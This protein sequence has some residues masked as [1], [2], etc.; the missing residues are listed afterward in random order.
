MSTIHRLSVILA[1]FLAY[2]WLVNGEPLPLSASAHTWFW[3]GLSGIV[4]FFLCDL[5][6]FKSMLI[7]GPRL[8]LLVFSLAPIIAALCGWIWLSEELSTRDPTPLGLPFSQKP[9]H[10]FHAPL[11][12]E[13]SW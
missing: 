8:T 6:L 2:G 13:G 7:I 3:L 4:G 5:F 1:L 10:S 11:D 12:E 9:T